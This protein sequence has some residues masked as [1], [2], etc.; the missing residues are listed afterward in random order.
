M[1]EYHLFILESDG[2]ENRNPIL[3]YCADDKVFGQAQRIADYEIEIW[4]GLR[5]VAVVKPPTASNPTS[6]PDVDQPSA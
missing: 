3:L 4:Q 2:A 1:A 5:R 6:Q